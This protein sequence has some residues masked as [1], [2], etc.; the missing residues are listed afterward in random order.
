MSIKNIAVLTSEGDAPSLVYRA[1][2]RIENYF[3]V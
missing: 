3:L 1:I 2:K